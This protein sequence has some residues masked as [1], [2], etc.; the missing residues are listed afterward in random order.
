[1]NRCCLL[2]LPLGVSL[3]AA[4]CG[5]AHEETIRRRAELLVGHLV[6]ENY[7]ACVELTDP[8]FVRRKGIDGTKTAYRILG[9]FAKLGNLTRDRVKIE[10]VS[11]AEDGTRA[12]VDLSLLSGDT[13]R[14]VQP[15]K[16]RRVEGQWYVEF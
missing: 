12:T 13:W 14:P 4:G 16:W 8:E 3:L 10:R 1:M 7:D 9:A 5:P 11:V 6:D 15:L 2:L